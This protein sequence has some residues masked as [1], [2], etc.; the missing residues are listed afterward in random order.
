MERAVHNLVQAW[1]FTGDKKYAEAAVRQLRAWFSDP[2]TRMNP[3]L[4]HAQMVKG[5]DTGR[6]TGIIDTHGLPALLDDILLL[7]GAPGWTD[8]DEKKLRVWN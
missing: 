7:H 1:Y 4:N 3:N 5:K 8:D 6:G 2:A